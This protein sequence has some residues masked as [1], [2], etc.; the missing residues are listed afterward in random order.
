MR[1]AQKDQTF[2][3]QVERFDRLVGL[4][5]KKHA[6][7]NGILHRA[8]SIF[9]FR[10]AQSSLQLLLQQRAFHKYHSRGLWTNIPVV[11]MRSLMSP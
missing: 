10:E 5:E 4:V 9:V 8:F 2:V 1:T 11:A 7:L 6:H 3:V